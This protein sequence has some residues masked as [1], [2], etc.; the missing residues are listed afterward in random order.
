MAGNALTLS[1][2]TVCVLEVR[3]ECS[4][5]PLLIGRKCR[6]YIQD[7][8]TLTRS[9]GHTV[10]VLRVC[11]FPTSVTCLSSVLKVDR[12]CT[13][14]EKLSVV[15][16][17]EKKVINPLWLHPWH[18]TLSG[19]SRDLYFEGPS[20]IWSWTSA[21]RN[22]H[23]YSPVASAAAPSSSNGIIFQPWSFVAE[24][25]PCYSLNSHGPFYELLTICMG[26]VNR[27]VTTM[28]RG[29]ISTFCNQ[30][31]DFM[32]WLQAITGKLASGKPN[33]VDKWGNI[34][35]VYLAPIEWHQL[36]MQHRGGKFK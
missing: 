8:V 29:E 11:V 10:I 25:Y 12:G 21:R 19:G 30:W 31:R 4:S 33:C 9:L 2:I 26:L 17:L 35:F 16:A 36:I 34:V 1:D 20:P 32:Y 28:W 23:H 27:G 24:S 5:S 13:D 7:E 14:V 15:K 3:S 18:L 22:C 6:A